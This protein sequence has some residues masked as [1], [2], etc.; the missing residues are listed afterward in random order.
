MYVYI[1]RVYAEARRPF[2]L[3]F[4]SGDFLRVPESFMRDVKIF[5]EDR[6]AQGKAISRLSFLSPLSSNV[7]GRPLSVKC[8][9]IPAPCS[10][11]PILGGDSP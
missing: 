10:K 3:S 11:E 4:F 7:H 8:L 5:T 6:R 1:Y 2:L 9:A